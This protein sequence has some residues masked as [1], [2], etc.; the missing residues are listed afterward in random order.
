MDSRD[1]LARKAVVKYQNFTEEFHRFT[2]RHI[3]SLVKIWSMDDQNIDEDLAEL[4]RRLM[5]TD[6]SCD[7]IAQLLQAGPGAGL[8]QPMAGH[9]SAASFKFSSLCRKCCCE[10]H[11]GLSHPFVQISASSVMSILLARRSVD[12][13]HPAQ[14]QLPLDDLDLSPDHDG[15]NDDHTPS[16]CDCS[17][18]ALLSNLNLDL[19]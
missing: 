12:Q 3:R 11:C 2:D 18:T 8:P 4:Q 1:G 17:L 14:L 13:G 6:Q 9:T 16:D 15:G 5:T 10:S 19:E 7:L